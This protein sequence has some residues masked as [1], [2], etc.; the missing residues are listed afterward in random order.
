MVIPTVSGSGTT[1]PTNP[2]REFGCRTKLVATL[3]SGEGLDGCDGGGCNDPS[4]GGGGGGAQT[5][6][7]ELL[8]VSVT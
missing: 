2:D 1:G 7:V 8:R 6:V 4:S 5:V 3:S